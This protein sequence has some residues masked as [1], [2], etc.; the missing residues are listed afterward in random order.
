VVLAADIKAWKKK[1]VRYWRNTPEVQD[2]LLG[3]MT[4]F[5]EGRERLHTGADEARLCFQHRSS[6]DMLPHARPSISS[7]RSNASGYWP[8]SPRSRID[9]LNV[10]FLVA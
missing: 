6:K 5:Y 10:S 4:Q 2:Y 8:T 3:A 9:N 7:E 1:P